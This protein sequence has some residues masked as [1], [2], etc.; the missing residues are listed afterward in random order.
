MLCIALQACQS[1][2][3]IDNIVSSTRLDTVLCE[4]MI[5]CAQLNGYSSLSPFLHDAVI[6]KR[7]SLGY[8]LISLCNDR[9]K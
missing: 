3:N 6:D 2:D 5:R 1:K 4:S 7:G 8:A 9:R